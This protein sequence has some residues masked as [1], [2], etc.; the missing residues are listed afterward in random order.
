MT[1]RD[2][3]EAK[4]QM[5]AASSY[6]ASRHMDAD[7]RERLL[8][9]NLPQVQYI[10]RRI[11]DRLPAQVPLEDLISAGVVGLIEALDRFD[12]NK[13]V[14]LKSFA[15]FRIRGAIL[16]SL[17][18]M[19]WGSRNLRRQGRRIEDAISK[20]KGELKRAPSET[21]LASELGMDLDEFLHLLGDLRGLSL[22]SLDE[23]GSDEKPGTEDLAEY[24]P[25]VAA[26]DPFFLCLQSE[27]KT[28][29][30]QALGGL[31]EKERQVLALYY[32]E[33]LTMKEVGLV[34]GVSES[35]VSQIHS[36]ALL[37]IRTMLREKMESRQSIPSE[38]N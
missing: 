8:M 4:K 31:D 33:E 29:I 36:I 16:D 20:L 3:K 30:A 23:I 34:L 13:N 21:E 18:D 2:R 17:R 10:A 15:K 27:M 7:E 37:Q 25:D 35:R 9:E 26:R 6:H 5:N 14:Q 28:M 32:F 11:H 22:G 24:R 12:P 19:D 38:A 1:K